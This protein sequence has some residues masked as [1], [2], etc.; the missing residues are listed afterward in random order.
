M[1]KAVLALRRAVL[2]S[3]AQLKPLTILAVLLLSTVFA[4]RMTVLFSYWYNDFYDSIQNLDESAFWHFLR[5]FA[6]LATVH[7]VRA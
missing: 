6:L 5:V 4:V 7:V 3:A 2:Q 1:G